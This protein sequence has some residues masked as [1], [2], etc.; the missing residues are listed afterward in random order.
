MAYA[1]LQS[2]VYADLTPAQRDLLVAQ[3]AAVFA[4]IAIALSPDPLGEAVAAAGVGI[5]GRVIGFVARLLGRADRVADTSK[6]TRTVTRYED[7]TKGRSVTNRSIDATRSEMETNLADAGFTPTM[8]RDGKVVIYEKDGV[9]YVF[10]SDKETVNV[11]SNGEVQLKLR[12][13]AN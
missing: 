12:L 13:D 6:A 10:R 9:Q 7:V 2:Q 5:G 4:N 8:S 3:Q 1:Q 11:L